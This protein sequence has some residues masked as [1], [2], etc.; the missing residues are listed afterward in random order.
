[1]NHLFLRAFFCLPFIYFSFAFDKKQYLNQL[2]ENKAQQNKRKS[3]PSHHEEIRPRGASESGDVALFEKRIFSLDKQKIFFILFD[4]KEKKRL[5]YQIPSYQ[6][7]QKRKEFLNYFRANYQYNEGR[8]ITRNRNR[9]NQYVTSRGVTYKSLVKKDKYG[10]YYT[11]VLEWREEERKLIARYPLPLKIIN[12]P[13]ISSFYVFDN[14]SGFAIKIKFET[15]NE[16]NKIIQFREDVL[17]FNEQFNS[18]LNSQLNF[19]PLP[20]LKVESAYQ[21]TAEQKKTHYLTD[22]N[23]DFKGRI[24]FYKDYYLDGRFIL[25]KTN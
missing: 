21:L 7:F 6:T 10:Y 2:L 3:Q 24:L 19:K 14:E 5:F 8:I 23:Y 15:L 16:D 18:Q 1:M 20:I 22:V 9:G 25:R 12:E 4:L 17:C 11:Q 13:T